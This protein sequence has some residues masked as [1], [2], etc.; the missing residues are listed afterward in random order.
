[1]AQEQRDPLAALQAFEG[2]LRLWPD[3]PWARYHTALVAEELGD[4]ERALAEYRYATR[5]EPGA[6]DART[7]GA[8][9]LLAQ[10]R[11]NLALLMLLT[12]AAMQPVIF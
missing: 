8:T 1:M 12:A 5:I 10:G 2:A 3:N 6:T 9:L 4:F 7:R 11:P